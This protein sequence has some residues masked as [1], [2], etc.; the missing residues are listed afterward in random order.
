M[1]LVSCFQMSSRMKK[2]S[3]TK[4]VFEQ[5]K[6]ERIKLIVCEEWRAPNKSAQL[7]SFSSDFNNIKLSELSNDYN[8]ICRKDKPET[9]IT[10]FHFLFAGNSFVG[11]SPWNH[12]LIIEQTHEKRNS[13]LY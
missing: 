10:S 3:V 7:F 2:A 6:I 4:N 11:L 1:L 5:E 9:N 12:F 8:N 13:I